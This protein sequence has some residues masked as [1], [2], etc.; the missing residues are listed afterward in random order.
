[1]ARSIA[2][3]LPL[4][5]L[6]LLV[7]CPDDT[8][9]SV[10]QRVDQPPTADLPPSVDGQQDQGSPLEAAADL[11]R[12]DAKHDGAKTDAKKTDGPPVG[13]DASDPCAGVSCGVANDCCS[14]AAYDTKTGPPGCAITGCKQPTC[15]ALGIAGPT[16]YCLKGK[17]LLAAGGTTCSGAVSCYLVDNCCECTALPAGATAAACAKLCLISTCT[18][19]GLSSAKAACVAGV[20][21]VTP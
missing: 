16:S 5:A 9:T 8:G 3:L 1:M 6:L 2:S 20:C 11:P 13:T 15:S 21:K 17:C 19:Y 7:A 14:C 18:S 12:S 4:A 10:D